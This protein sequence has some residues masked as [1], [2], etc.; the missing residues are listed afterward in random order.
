MFRPSEIPGPAPWLGWPE[1]QG[2]SASTLSLARPLSSLL[3]ERVAFDLVTTDFS[4]PPAVP[5]NSGTM[6]WLVDRGLRLDSKYSTNSTDATTGFS[7]C[8]KDHRRGMVLKVPCLAREGVGAFMLM[9]LP[10]IPRTKVL[11]SSPPFSCLERLFVKMG[12]SGTGGRE[13]PGAELQDTRL[14]LTLPLL[15]PSLRSQWSDK[16]ELVEPLMELLADQDGM[17]FRF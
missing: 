1:G 6:D 15:L 5:V 11:D 7:L 3:A 8:P 9:L 12:G 13:G 2:T 14:P 4:S 10:F 16:E 17:L